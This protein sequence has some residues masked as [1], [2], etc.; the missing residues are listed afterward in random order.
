MLEGGEVVSDPWPGDFIEGGAVKIVQLSPSPTQAYPLTGLTW[1]NEMTDTGD[2]ELDTG[3]VYED[4]L[5]ASVKIDG[6]RFWRLCTN[7]HADYGGASIEDVLAWGDP[8]EW[9]IPG[10]FWGKNLSDTFF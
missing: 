1:S 7:P 8:A 9:E 2:P 10:E 6:K 4:R 3:E 5:F